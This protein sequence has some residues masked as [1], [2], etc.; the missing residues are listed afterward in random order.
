VISPA[1][2]QATAAASRYHGAPRRGALRAVPTTIA[3]TLETP[4]AVHTNRCWLG[5]VKFSTVR[6]SIHTAKR[7]TP[8]A[9]TVS[10]HLPGASRP[11]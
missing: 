4:I 11:L 8:R 2:R 9:D 7:V 6:R 10:W 3:V 5:R 1:I